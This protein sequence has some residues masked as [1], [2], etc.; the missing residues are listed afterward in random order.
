MMTAPKIEV[1][2]RVVADAADEPVVPATLPPALRRYF[3]Q[4]RRALITELRQLEKV[5][6]VEQSVP[7][8]QRPH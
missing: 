6:G 7:E 8:R 3:E 5:L 4:R 2:Y 1:E